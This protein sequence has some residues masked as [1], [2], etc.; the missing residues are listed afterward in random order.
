MAR[1]LELA[2]VARL[3]VWYPK[4]PG[5]LLY[6]GEPFG[7]AASP[8]RA[9]CFPMSPVVCFLIVGCCTS[10]GNAFRTLVSLDLLARI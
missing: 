7:T 3:R 4:R 5:C 1:G 6:V 9:V 2:Q 10:V 8:F